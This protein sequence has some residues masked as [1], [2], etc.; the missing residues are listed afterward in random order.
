MTKRKAKELRVKPGPKSTYSDA[1]AKTICTEIMSGKSLRT[2][3][4]QEGFPHR[5]TVLTWLE[6]HP[7]FASKYARARSIYADWLEEQMAE[8]AD[9][10]TVA[11]WQ[12][13]K[14]RITTMQWRAS[15]LAPKKYGDRLELAGDKENPLTVMLEAGKSLDAKLERLIARGSGETE[16]Q[17]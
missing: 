3:C 8:E 2:I 13:R 5:V 10:A 17:S 7:D 12:V 1:I 11:D 14:L 9:L 4:E 15:K 16:G 6:D